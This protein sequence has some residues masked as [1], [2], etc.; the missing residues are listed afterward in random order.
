MSCN[1][2]HGY[3]GDLGFRVEGMDLKAFFNDINRH[4]EKTRHCLCSKPCPKFCIASKPK[5]VKEAKAAE[6]IEKSEREKERKKPED[7]S[8]RAGENARDK[9]GEIERAGEMEKG[10]EIE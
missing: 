5:C 7:A 3:N 10:G 4:K 2:M 1:D 9:G 8:E 6:A